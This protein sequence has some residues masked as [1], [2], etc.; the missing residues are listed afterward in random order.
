MSINRK[1]IKDDRR[2]LAALQVGE[3]ALSRLL[4]TYVTPRYAT[5]RANTQTSCEICAF[6]GA[7]FNVQRPAG[8]VCAMLQACCTPFRADRSSVYFADARNLM[9]SRKRKAKQKKQ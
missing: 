6:G 7:E 3:V 1:K 9:S 2:Q 4:D 5:V 8:T